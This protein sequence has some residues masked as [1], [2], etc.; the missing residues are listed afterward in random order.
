MSGKPKPLWFYG[1]GFI[2]F[3]MLL[4]VLVIMVQQMLTPSTSTQDIRARGAVK[5]AGIQLKG[6]VLAVD[7]NSRTVTIE[8]LKMAQTN[9]EFPG[10]WTGN[11]REDVDMSLLIPSDTVTMD[12]NP[13]TLSIEN[14]SF[15][16]MAME[17]MP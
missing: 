9:A 7:A 12:A 1:G 2:G 15:Q 3:G 4:I 11:A 13:P 6:R 10:V 16:I 5:T 8:N 14:R 17:V